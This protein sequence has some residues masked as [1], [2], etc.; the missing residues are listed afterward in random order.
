[1]LTSKLLGTHPRQMLVVFGT[2][3][4][5]DLATVLFVAF[6]R[7]DHGAWDEL[8]CFGNVIA[9][10]RSDLH[11]Y[12]NAC[13]FHCLGALHPAF[14]R[15]AC[16]ANQLEGVTITEHNQILDVNTRTTHGRVVQSFAGSRRTIFTTLAVTSAT[17]GTT[18]TARLGAL[19]G[20]RRCKILCDFY[21]LGLFDGF[22]LLHD[23]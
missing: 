12:T 17:T 5:N 6:D 9:L 8:Q 23:T 13:D 3:L 11:H 19:L 2:A 15:A 22:Y 14:F 16:F 18:G 10:L 1:M 20:F 4:R 21:V 7:N